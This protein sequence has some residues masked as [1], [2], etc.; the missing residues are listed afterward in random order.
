MSTKEL[1]NYKMFTVLFVRRLLL[2]FHDICILVTYLDIS[3]FSVS[4]KV[5]LQ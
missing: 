1:V 5:F 3:N 2:S 4:N